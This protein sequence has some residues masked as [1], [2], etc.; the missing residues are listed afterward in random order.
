MAVGDAYVFPGFLTPVLTQL[1]FPKPPT[2]FLI[3]FY[4]W[5][6]KIRLKEKSPQ[7]GIELTTT[8]SWVLPSLQGVRQLSKCHFGVCLCVCPSVR[9]ITSLSMY[10]FQNKLFSLVI[11][12]A[13]WR[14]HS[15]SLKVKVISTRQVVPGLWTT[16]FQV[17]FFK[18][19][20]ARRV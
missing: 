10:E 4:R 18:K 14:F 1:F 15:G 5:E 20:E 7:P 17:G 13:I 9:T 8:G 19:K 2:T 12:S 16:Y 11:R 6:A 3:C